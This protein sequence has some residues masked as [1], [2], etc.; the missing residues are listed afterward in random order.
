MNIIFWDEYYET[1]DNDKPSS[2]YDGVFD[3]KRLD[4]VFN[5]EIKLRQAD[6]YDGY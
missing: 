3:I 2:R 4:F 1:W 5:V 6:Y